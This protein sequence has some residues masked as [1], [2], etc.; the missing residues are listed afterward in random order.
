MKKLF[1]GAAFSALLALPAF[2]GPCSTGEY[3]SCTICCKS[4][5]RVT[6]DRNVCVGQCADYL[7]TGK[8]F[9]SFNSLKRGQ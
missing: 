5:P 1:F 2:A 6:V 7:R 8:N 3:K 9:S 4:S